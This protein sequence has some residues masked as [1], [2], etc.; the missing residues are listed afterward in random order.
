MNVGFVC[1]TRMFYNTYDEVVI[2]PTI[3]PEFFKVSPLC[4]T[5]NEGVLKSMS[6]HCIL[7]TK[8]IEMFVIRNLVSDFFADWLA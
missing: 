1:C 2:L 4:T 8:G 7:N 3:L 5:Q 6:F